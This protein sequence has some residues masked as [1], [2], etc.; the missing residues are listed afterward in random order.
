MVYDVEFPDGTIRGYGANIS[1]D[2]MYSKVD[3]EGFSHSFLS[4]ILDFA[5][6]TTA[7]QKGYQYIITKSGQRRMQKSTVEWKLLIACKYGSEQGITLSVM[8]S[9]NPIELS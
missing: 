8:K 7:V 6:Y 9:F 4:G 1:A 3:S 2:N 5:K